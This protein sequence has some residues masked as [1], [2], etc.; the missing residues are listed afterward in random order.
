MLQTVQRVFSPTY[1][2]GNEKQ[3]WF[4]DR[5][6]SSFYKTTGFSNPA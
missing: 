4:A 2:K 5:V 1:T 3:A 6:T